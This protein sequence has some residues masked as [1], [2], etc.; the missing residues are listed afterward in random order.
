[1]LIPSKKRSSTYYR[2]VGKHMP[3]VYITGIS[4]S[5][6][7]EVLK[8]LQ[9][10]GYEAYGTDEH[11]IAA[12]YHN[13]TGEELANPPTRTEDRTPEWGAR[14]TWKLSRKRVE[15]LASKS[16]GK[17]IFLC[18]VAANENEVWDLFSHVLALVIDDETLKQ[19]IMTRTNNTFGKASH[20]LENIGGWQRLAEQNYQKFGIVMIDA[21]RP[22]PIVVDDIL[23]KVRKL[24]A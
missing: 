6:K 9:S 20:E 3:L 7:S 22:I 17:L 1:M 13:Q 24:T 11:G 23:R 16:Q 10:R 19:R 12:F 5:G 15:W 18:G 8:V 21:T 2:K 4:G 14:Y